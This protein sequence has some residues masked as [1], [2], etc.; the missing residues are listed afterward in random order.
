MG[1]QDAAQVGGAAAHQ[2]ICGEKEGALHAIARAGPRH[3][4][5]IVGYD[6]YV[7]GSKKLLTSHYG[8]AN[9]DVSPG[10]LPAL[11]ASRIL[12]PR[13]DKIPMGKPL[14]ILEC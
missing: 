4:A 1:C 14:G 2:G 9:I 12:P 10:F 3:Y 13:E 11:G 7:I 6:F 8:F 5:R